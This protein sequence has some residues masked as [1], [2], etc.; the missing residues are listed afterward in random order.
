MT[1]NTSDINWIIPGN[2]SVCSG[3]HGKALAAG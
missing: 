2:E 3:D 1:D